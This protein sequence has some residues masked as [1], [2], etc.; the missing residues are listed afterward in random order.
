MLPACQKSKYTW[1]TYYTPQKE[2]QKH[3][4]PKKLHVEFK[5]VQNIQ[6]NKEQRKNQKDQNKT[7]SAKKRNQK[8]KKPH[9]QFFVKMQAKQEKKKKGKKI[10]HLQK[11]PAQDQMPPSQCVQ[12]GAHPKQKVLERKK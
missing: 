8:K 10:P 1:H 9:P 7:A 5:R 4:W 2:Q 6:P 3:I 11:R 12:F